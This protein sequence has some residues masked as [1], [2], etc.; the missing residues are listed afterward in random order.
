MT[1]DGMLFPRI[2][3]SPFPTFRR[4]KSMMQAENLQEA[5][6]VSEQ[7]TSHLPVIDVV[8]MGFLDVI[9]LL[10]VFLLM[11]PIFFARPAS[12]AVMKRNFVNYF[13]NPTGY[14][15]LCMFVLLTSF[16]AFWPHDF[17]AQNL[18]NLD[19]LN[20][21][22]PY[23]MLIFIPAITMGIWAEEVRAGTDELLLTLPARDFDIVIGKYFAAVFVFTV[24]LLFSQL[25]NFAVLIAL[26]GGV[27]DDGILMST[28][29]G[30]W[31]V[32]IAMLSLGMLA[33]FLTNNLTVGF[34]FG[35]AL[36]A[37]FAFFSNSDVIFSSRRWVE[38]MK[39]WSLLKRF[40]DFGRGLIDVSGMVYFAGIVVIG[41]YLSLV[42]IG[43]R[44]WGGGRDGRGMFLH[45]AIR[46]IALILFC[47]A[48]VMVFQH[49]PLNRAARIDL[50]KEKVNTLSEKSIDLLKN[51]DPIDDNRRNVIQIDAF[52]SNGLP[53]EYVQTRYDLINLLKE[54]DVLGGDR[55]QLNL[56]E[57]VQPFSQESILAEQRFGIRPKRVTV[58]SRGRLRDEEIV[59]GIAFSSGLQRIVIP[60][61][62]YGMSVEYEL[63]RSINTVANKKRKKIGVVQT[64]AMVGGGVRILSNRRIPHPKSI[65]ISEL[66]KQYDVVRIDPA[67][68]FDI[69]EDKVK[70][71]R[72]YDCLLVV[73]PS[74]M[75]ATSLD[76][77]LTAMNQG[78]PTAIFE[79]PFPIGNQLMNWQVGTMDA[80]ILKKFPRHI[81]P[82]SAARLGNLPSNDIRKLYDL[83]Q[84][85][86]VEEI[87]AQ[88]QTTGMIV[89]QKNSTYPQSL[90][91]N[92]HLEF[93][94][95]KQTPPSL[96][97]KYGTMADHPVTD[98]IDE[99]AFP[100]AGSIEPRPNSTREFIPL[101]RTLE[102][103]SI[104]VDAYGSTAGINELVKKVR[105]IE[106]GQKV[107]AAEIKSGVTDGSG[108]GIRAIYVADSDLFADYFVSLRDEPTQF[109][110]EFR[111]QNVSFFLNLI[112]YL[113]GEDRY[114]E[115]RNRV[116]KQ[117]TLRV[118][119]AEREKEWEAVSRE[120]NA[121]QKDIDTAMNVAM[122]DFT[123]KSI[124]L[125]NRRRAILTSKDRRNTEQQLKAIDAQRNRLAKQR[126]DVLRQKLQELQ[127]ELREKERSIR[128]EA[129]QKIDAIQGR[130]KLWAVLLPP[131][132][133]MIL[134]L[135]VFTR[136]RLL[137]REGI[138]KSR[139]RT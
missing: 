18:A 129:E 117:N 26:T 100:F 102:A 114:K 33:S 22:L 64:D 121:F 69:W 116:P 62:N 131:I 81:M 11:T 111:Y 90:F 29:L 96:R 17:F 75:D 84:I 107:L 93:M 112:D 60:F 65:I 113:A 52:I 23:I 45:L 12:L 31:F 99:I 78:Q 127:I 95:I 108:P 54:F 39:D 15:F 110:V 73:Q 83:L 68:K 136:R 46:S 67:K 132:P 77:L 34:I 49:S 70:G 125:D 115:I 43:K 123:E 89:W 101:I 133:P 97:R 36:N 37:P 28:Y 50:S 42:L 9:F 88:G 58:R 44:H 66:E 128:L 3:I 105:G 19:Q 82:S 79:D 71:L 138:A 63:V 80:N 2:V 137:E 126:D 30:Y 74:K 20:R 55:I 51:L 134:G 1:E 27:V 61:V 57:D 10:I 35:V 53:A 40:G 59:M 56:H 72:K 106:G 76:N 24:S 104:A 139:I 6:E 122:K 103:G 13:S 14:V 41:I 21:Y 119:E 4:K 91:L 8:Y 86:P 130:Y 98:K 48:T 87:R 109:D 25:S 38:V 7:V 32:G 85:Q 16:A 124:T 94:S 5:Q 47:V 92:K 135:I 120:L 118:V